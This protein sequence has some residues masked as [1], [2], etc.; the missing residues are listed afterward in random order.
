MGLFDNLTGK[1]KE[2]KKEK[3]QRTFTA[4][5]WGG[6]RGEVE[7]VMHLIATGHTDI[8][9]A[10]FGQDFISKKDGQIKY[11]EVKT[12]T[13]KLSKLQQKRKKQKKGNYKVYRTD[14][15]IF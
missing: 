8:K 4:S 15:S 1:E 12:G 10:P 3:K 5:K 2:T 14:R 7:G 9:R 11:T 13:A 6:K